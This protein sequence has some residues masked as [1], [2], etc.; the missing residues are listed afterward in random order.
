MF[1]YVF[2]VSKIMTLFGLENMFYTFSFKIMIYRNIQPFSQVLIKSPVFKFGGKFTEDA[3][4]SCFVATDKH[5]KIIFLIF[6]QVGN[7][8]NSSSID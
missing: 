2:E 5:F 4:F 8:E 6:I 7:G 3:I 1:I